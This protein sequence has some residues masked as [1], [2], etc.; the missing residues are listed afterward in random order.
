M[1]KNDALFK[2]SEVFR[3][4]FKEEE[5][6]L[7]NVLNELTLMQNKLKNLIDNFL[8]SPGMR[9]T[10]KVLS[11]QIANFISIQNEKQSV[12]K[13]KRTIKENSLNLA[14]KTRT[15]DDGDEKDMILNNIFSILKKDKKEDLKIS[16][17]NKSNDTDLDLEIKKRLEQ[18]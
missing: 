16:E 9:G 6:K 14:L 3:E 1:D 8:E 11:D 2:D 12:L 13:D 17:E 7:D 5:E 4:Y 15:S 18:Q 10:Q